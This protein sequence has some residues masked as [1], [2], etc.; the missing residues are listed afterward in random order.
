[1]TSGNHARHLRRWIQESE[2]AFW[3]CDARGVIR[4]VSDAAAKLLNCDASQLVGISTDR[5]LMVDDH[6]SSTD[7]AAQAGNPSASDAARWVATAMCP[8]PDWT[9]R[10]GV[11]VPFGLT[12]GDSESPASRQ[13]IFV[14]TPDGGW[15]AHIVA[16]DHAATSIEPSRADHEVNERCLARHRIRIADR[17]R[18]ALAGRSFEVDLARRQLELARQWPHH[19]AVRGGVRS[20]RMLLAHSVARESHPTKSSAK[21]KG[22]LVGNQGGPHDE[23][24]VVL[25]ADLMDEELFEAT[26]Q[27]PLARSEANPECVLRLIIDRIESASKQVEARLLELSEK[28]GSRLRMIGCFETPAERRRSETLADIDP[29]DRLF[30]LVVVDVPRLSDRPGDIQMVA[31]LVLDYWASIEGKAKHPHMPIGG[32]RFDDEALD[33]VCL[34]PWP[35]DIAELFDVIRQAMTQTSRRL[36]A[37]GQASAATTFTASPVG[38]IA[39]EDLPLHVRSYLTATSGDATELPSLDAATKDLERRLIIEALRQ[40]Q[41]NRAEAARRLDIS[42]GRLLRKLDEHDIAIDIE[43]AIESRAKGFDT[44]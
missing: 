10:V 21:S 33:R 1:M 11:V 15:L 4:Y 35:S 30:D 32:F 36:K 38:R 43:V 2:A 17:S 6:A 16:A 14:R 20:T 12:S 31:Q 23:F 27:R 24:V 44:N 40:C 7:P 13:V 26:L 41:N 3:A 29:I 28:M 37:H 9:R 25:D 39:V 42:R 18:I 34:Y 8:P 19:V 22:T 5:P